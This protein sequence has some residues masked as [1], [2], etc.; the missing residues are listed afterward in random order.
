[1]DGWGRG[2]VECERFYERHLTEAPTRLEGMAL[3]HFGPFGVQR[4]R[5][6]HWGAWEIKGSAVE[7]GRRVG[8]ASRNNHQIKRMPLFGC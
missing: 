8:M 7:A 6:P 4:E 5:G 1:M 3:A 2:L